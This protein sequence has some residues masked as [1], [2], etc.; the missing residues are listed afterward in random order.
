MPGNRHI[1]CVSQYSILSVPLSLIDRKH[2]FTFEANVCVKMWEMLLMHPCLGRW[3]E[4]SF[5]EFLTH[6]IN[7]RTSHLQEGGG[8][9]AESLEKRK[10]I[11][12]RTL[13]K[14]RGDVRKQTWSQSKMNQ[15]FAME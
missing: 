9:S 10:L 11:I 15:R 2:N 8:S 5:Y 13:G 1:L 12:C 7:R 4:S 6:K 3:A 14:F